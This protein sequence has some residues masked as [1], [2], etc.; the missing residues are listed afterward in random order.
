MATIDLA[1]RSGQQAITQ[2]AGGVQ[3]PYAVEAE[4]D[5][6]AAVTEKGS[7]LAQG[8]VVQ[9]L[10]VPADTIVLLVTAMAAEEHAGTS[11]DLTLD[12]GI[13]GGDVDQW[14][15]GWDFD[16]A[17]VGDIPA[18]AAGATLPTLVTADDTID[19][20]LTTMTG[21]TTGGKIRIRALLW[22]VS[23]HYKAPGRAALGS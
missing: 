1:T 9:V 3:V 13:T 8:D 11:T 20:L 21:T 16:A 23:E 19:V 14:V 7:A 10:D 17:S 2:Y 15:D 6:A 18:I 4:L 5:F 22:D 12:F